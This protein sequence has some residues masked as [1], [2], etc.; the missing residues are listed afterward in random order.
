AMPD[1]GR[2]M[3][4]ATNKTLD[5]RAAQTRDMA[6]GEYIALAVS[7]TGTG[8]PP[9]VVARVFEPFYTTKPIGQGTGLGLSMV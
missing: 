4:E 7:D 5:A 9:E 1:G 3:I 6:A 2:I 8:M